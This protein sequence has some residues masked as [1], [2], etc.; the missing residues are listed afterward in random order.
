MLNNDLK[1][2]FRIIAGMAKSGFVLSPLIE[3]TTEFELLYGENDLLDNKQVKS[4]VIT[5]RNG[6]TMLWNN[7]YMVTF[8]QIKTSYDAKNKT[9]LPSIY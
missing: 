1:K 6:K 8:S 9:T 3:N 7:E 2:Q 5:P 4:L